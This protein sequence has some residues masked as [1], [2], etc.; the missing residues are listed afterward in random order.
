MCC[1][2]GV[3]NAV[4]RMALRTPPTRRLRAVHDERLADRAAARRARA[5]GGCCATTTPPTSPGC[6]PAACG[7]SSSGRARPAA[8]S[9]GDSPRPAT[10]SPSSRP[11]GP[12][13]PVVS[14]FDA[15]A[16][17][18]C[19]VPGPVHP[20]PGARRVGCGERHADVDR[21]SRPVPRVGLGRRR[22]RAGPGAGATPSR[23]PTSAPSTGRC[24]PRRPTP[25]RS[26]W[27]ARRPAGDGSRRLPRRRRGRGRQRTS[28]RR[29]SS[30]DGG[31]A[32]ASASPTAGPCPADAVAAVRRRDRITACCSGRPASTI[33]SVG[34]ACATTSG[35]R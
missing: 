10:T 19:G 2:G 9:P 4:M 35:C 5:A 14:L 34:E 26:S 12:V 21:R 24:S 20:R 18:G 3:V 28:R 22:G 17:P 32:T 16:A 1:H 27:P 6:R 13:P 23:R 25:R 15:M 31:R 30:C 29:A 7:G 8:S 11:G 33:P